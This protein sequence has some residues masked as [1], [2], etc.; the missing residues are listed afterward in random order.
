MK[1]CNL[2]MSLVEILIVIAI[3]GLLAAIMIP[4]LISSR[5]RA[6][7]TSVIHYLR[8]VAIKQTDYHI[9]H[10]TYAA[11]EDLLV[12]V[13]RNASVIVE[14]WTGDVSSFCTQAKHPSGKTY[15]VETDGR[16]LRGN[17]T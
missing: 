5:N 1:K 17:C 8:T 6:H 3:I 13:R 12:G 16:V 4:N 11:T 7:E 15:K 2:G 9:D 14:V 10:S